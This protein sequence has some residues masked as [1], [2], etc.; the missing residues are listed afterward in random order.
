MVKV[1]DGVYSTSD[2]AAHEILLQ[3]HQLSEI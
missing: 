2:N 1:E 3:L